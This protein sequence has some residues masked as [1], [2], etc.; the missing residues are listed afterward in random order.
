MKNVKLS[1]SPAYL[2]TNL[3]FY[4]FVQ[5]HLIRIQELGETQLTD[6]QLKTLLATLTGLLG[7]LSKVLV[8]IRKSAIT[9]EIT[10]LDQARDN[11][12]RALLR[13]LKVHELATDQTVLHALAELQALLKPYGNVPR[14][15]LEAETS[16]IESITTA[17][18]SARY[19]PLATTLG[20]DGYV[21]RL[22]ADNAAFSTRYNERTVEYIDKDTTDMRELR[23]SITGYYSLLC[24]YVEVMARLE[25]APLFSTV[26][27]IIDTI[28]GQY[29]A[30]Q[31][32]SAARKPNEANAG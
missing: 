32:R 10:T 7:D 23:S 21:T 11:S 4:E 17:M 3:E 16:A 19:T 20:L 30:Q 18:T 26:F 13:A 29:S 28:R 14:L 25:T 9:E 12:M 1:A 27:T 15:T 5:S 6:E 24:D 31:A 2:L 22:K 8:H